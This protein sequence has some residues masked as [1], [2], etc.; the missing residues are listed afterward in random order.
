M[1]AVSLPVEVVHQQTQEPEVVTATG[2]AV[3]TAL[4]AALET[5]QEKFKNSEYSIVVGFTI[6]KTDFLQ[7]MFA[8][9]LPAH[10][11]RC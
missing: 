10:F 5:N 9:A 4:V 1:G 8:H 3:I 7:Y 11:A 2:D 6:I